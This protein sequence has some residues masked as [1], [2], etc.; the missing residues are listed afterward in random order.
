MSLET[1]RDN[2]RRMSAE[3]HAIL[4]QRAD[5]TGNSPRVDMSPRR[6]AQVRETRSAS[7]ALDDSGTPEFINEYRVIR[8]VGE[9]TFAGVY[10]VEREMNG[11][12]VVF[13]AKVLYKS[14][15]R[16]KR[17]IQRQGRK[18]V[19]TTAL[20]N[21][22]REVALMKKLEHP[23]IVK[24][25]E[26]IDDSD[27]DMLVMITEYMGGGTVMDWDDGYGRFTFG[28]TDG[29]MPEQDAAWTMKAVLL[30]LGYLHSNH[31]AHQD[32][33]P[34]N[35]LRSDDG[36]VKIADFGVSHFFEEEETKAPRPLHL[37]TR[38]SSRGQL[39]TTEGTWAFWAPE[40]VKAKVEG[41]KPHWS[42][43]AT[44]LWAA[45]VCLWVFIFGTLPFDPSAGPSGLFEEIEKFDSESCEFPR[46]IHP[47]LEDFIRR[48]LQKA[49]QQRMT[50]PDAL[51]HEWMKHHC[52]DDTHV[53]E[54]DMAAIA[55][56]TE[57]EINR[58]FSPMNHLIVIPNS[59]K[60]MSHRLSSARE[61]FT[62]SRGASLGRSQVRLQSPKRRPSMEIAVSPGV[63][64][65]PPQGPDATV[66]L[67]LDKGA[68]A[69][70]PEEA[71]KPREKTPFARWGRKRKGEVEVKP[72][73]PC[74][75][76]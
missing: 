13:A 59:V 34:D 26:I 71:G 57:D 50:V 11:E 20:D 61:L 2:R 62:N 14:V 66:S 25:H 5:P 9:G 32:L 72:R 68:D 29:P 33:K 22:E 75:I 39:S 49:P 8:K 18:T 42:A 65:A 15:L 1:L 51:N 24:L 70:E 4:A 27:A 43:Y 63:D 76:M 48:L 45:G 69:A 10:E 67:S 17:N 3:A 6:A 46:E 53:V 73:R 31:I 35:I 60:S 41:G 38:Q 16:K 30:G 47:R 19:I 7:V 12:I 37:L 64:D 23:C 54:L 74:V 52:G 40:M 36:R 56:P 21:V 55:Q 44:D 58:A 28:D